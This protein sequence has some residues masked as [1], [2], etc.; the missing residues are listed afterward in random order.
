MNLN[1]EN[2]LSNILL[3]LKDYYE[4]H[5]GV[6]RNFDVQTIRTRPAHVLNLLEPITKDTI[7]NNITEYVC[8]ELGKLLE[9]NQYM[10]CDLLDVRSLSGN[11]DK[12]IQFNNSKVWFVETTTG[13]TGK[14]F[15]AIKN[16]KE[17]FI[18]AAYL[19]KCRKRIFEKAN[20]HN[21]FFMI[22]QVDPIL[23][24][25]NYRDGTDNGF[26]VLFD[27]MLS[28]EPEWIFSTAILFKKYYNYFNAK[29]IEAVRQLNV[30][31]IELTSQTLLPEEKIDIETNI[32]SKI[33]NNFGCREVW[34]IAYECPCGKL[35]V[36]DDYLIVQLIDEQ[37]NT[38]QDY[39][40]IGQVVV[41]S[42]SNKTMPFIKYLVGDYAKFVKY[43]CPCGLRSP[44]IEFEDGRYYEKLIN[45][46][47]Y[48]NVIFR[49]ILRTLYFHD[50][51][52]DVK[53]IKIIQNAPF[54]IN[55][56]LIKTVIND[57]VF[58][59]R[60]K[61]LFRLSIENSD[62]YTIEFYYTYPFE[63]PQYKFKEQIFCNYLKEIEK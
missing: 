13:S 51:F 10:L 52:F 33:I 43:K 4:Y 58:E 39:N 18:E 40:T 35:H 48:G 24:Q 21:G 27:Y 56:F 53:K 34:N 28:K 12:T 3:L 8:P 42:L 49:K 62:A 29:N 7:L 41:T 22:H 55:V 20:I 30:K 16:M 26:E 19:Y 50:H 46:N 47:Y 45:S 9:E 1:Q 36:N 54:H 59:N 17:R 15:P 37:G 38:I 23:K 60:F 44:I 63:E 57:K 25:M 2:K 6:L 5:K 14:P 61:E 31:F 11:H 32:N